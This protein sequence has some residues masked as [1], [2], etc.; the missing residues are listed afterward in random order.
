MTSPPPPNPTAPS[1]SATPPQPA[2]TSPSTGPER[3][4]P[5]QFTATTTNPT[6]AS[7][8]GDCAAPTPNLIYDIQARIDISSDPFARV[9]SVAW[10]PEE[11]YADPTPDEGEAK[12]D[13]D[14]DDDA[15]WEDM[16]DNRE[17]ELE[18]EQDCLS[19]IQEE[20][21]DDD[22]NA[23]WEEMRDNTENVVK[24]EQEC[25]AVCE[26]VKPLINRIRELDV[27]EEED[28]YDDVNAFSGSLTWDP[29]DA[30]HGM[31]DDD[32]EECI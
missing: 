19:D 16:H 2:S 26:E 22:D 14:E 5:R 25:H 23:E 27:E 8:S 11:Q 1:P 4:I 17:D 31:F 20:E 28:E 13:E 32:D 29:A 15:E 24:E 9:A 7:E 3:Q 18:E 6:H 21:E 12:D 30:E 10:D